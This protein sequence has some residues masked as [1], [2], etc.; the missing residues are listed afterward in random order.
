ML[1]FGTPIH[2][3]RVYEWKIKKGLSIL[4]MDTGEVLTH[5]EELAVSTL[6]KCYGKDTTN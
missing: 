3:G 1:F 4:G 6:G 5:L 2:C